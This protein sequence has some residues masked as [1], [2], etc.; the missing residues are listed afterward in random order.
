MIKISN[1]K[2]SPLDSNYKK[3]VAKALKT[4]EENILNIEI[5]R[6][7]LDCRKRDFIHYVLTFKAEVKNEKSFLTLNNVT[8][9]EDN[10]YVFPYES[11]KNEKIVI[12]GSGPA[13]LFCGLILARCGMKPII[14]ERG[15]SVEKRKAS[16]DTFFKTGKL[17]LSSNIQFGEG[18]A[19]TFSVGKLTCGLSNKKIPFVLDEFVKHG[20]PEEIKYLAKPHIGTDYLYTTVKNIREEIISLGGEFLFETTLTDIIVENNSISAVVT[21]K[22]TIKCDK[23]VLATGHSSRDTYKMLY[24]KGAQMEKKP[25]S[26]GV[27]I[28]HK[29]KHINLIQYKSEKWAETLPAADYKLSC[30]KDDRGAYTFCMCPGGVVVCGASGERQVVTNGMSYFAR[31][32]E[33]SNAALLVSVLPEDIEGGV[34]EAIK[35]Q[36]DLE[37]KAFIKGGE[38]YYA[39][40]QLVSDFLADKES[41][42]AG[43][44]KPSYLPGVKYTSIGDVLPSFV[45]DMLKY[46]IIDFDKKMK[47]FNLGD[48][49]LTG[50]ETRSSAPLRILRDETFQSNIKGLL[51][52]GEGAGYAGGIMSSAL[53]GINCAEKI[54]GDVKMLQNT[55][56][57]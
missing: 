4:K 36:E 6:K 27:R 54:I 10:P 9:Y 34:L 44:V 17:N 35:F 13:G 51:P 37:E 24:E 16:I 33:N 8:L 23:L 50:V 12:A 15:E 38:N 28:E 7:S 3:A 21:D 47:G 25:F 11:G 45:I 56:R 5:L 26:V 18:G 42:K 39:P 43:E 20:A 1:V 40:V 31:D 48:A 22:G 30:H 55:K 57:Q 2:L 52:I 41:T 19:G 46:A 32:E 29:R 14:L 53:D 49:V